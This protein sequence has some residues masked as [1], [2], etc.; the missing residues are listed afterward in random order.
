MSGRERK[1]NILLLYLEGSAGTSPCIGFLR[2]H[3]R[4]GQIG[5]RETCV[6]HT[7]FSIFKQ[8]IRP[9]YLIIA[10]RDLSILKFCKINFWEDFIT[11]I[12]FL[13]NFKFSNITDLWFYRTLKISHQK[14]IFG[15]EGVQND[16][17]R[18]SI[19]VPE[20][21]AITQANQ[22]SLW[23]LA[24]FIDF[25]NSAPRWRYHIPLIC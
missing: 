24:N 8:G 22:F 13:H 21:L 18:P 9:S 11:K 7:L 16:L 10:E 2:I 25:S 6:F 19:C 12:L 1:V 17:R 5:R 4:K 3:P 14:P 20:A 23:F 15:V